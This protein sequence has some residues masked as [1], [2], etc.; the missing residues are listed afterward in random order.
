MPRVGRMHP[1][2]R[3]QPGGA[4]IRLRPL[5][6]ELLGQCQRTVC[7]TPGFFG[8]GPGVQ[9]SWSGVQSSQKGEAL[10]LPSSKLVSPAA[11]PSPDLGLPLLFSY[12]KF[13][14]EMQER[15]VLLRPRRVGWQ[16]WG[17]PHRPP[18]THS[19]ARE[20]PE[21]HPEGL[22]KLQ[23][24]HGRWHLLG[25]DVWANFAPLAE[26][27][28][29]CVET[30]PST[31]V[32]HASRA[33]KRCCNRRLLGKSFN[34][35]INFSKSCSQGVK[36]T[37]KGTDLLGENG[38]TERVLHLSITGKVVAAGSCLPWARCSLQEGN[39]GV[40][41]LQGRCSPLPCAIRVSLV[42]CHLAGIN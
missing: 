1:P 5:Q 28:Q 8:G 33:H 19:W 40:C 18:P 25:G 36:P 14:S 26:V 39:Y 13:S 24:Q 11:L 20:H 42:P 9:H 6:L 35:I 38:F 27:L 21:K 37:K 30:T 17:L 7:V 41:L 2:A 3:E 12:P 23:L 31:W 29:Q 4:R 16:C 10:A 22:P 15:N 34:P 32:P